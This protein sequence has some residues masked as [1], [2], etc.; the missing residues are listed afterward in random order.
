VRLAGLAASGVSAYRKSS[1]A[2][3]KAILQAR[4]TVLQACETVLQAR[5]I[6]R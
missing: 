3:G 1:Y 2:I 4:E 6:I 5:E